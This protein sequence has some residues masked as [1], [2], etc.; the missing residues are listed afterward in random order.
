MEA[1]SG[2]KKVYL[3]TWGKGTGQK[4]TED[5]AK[6]SIGLDGGDM[7]AGPHPSSTVVWHPRMG[8]ALC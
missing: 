5:P 2:L 6:R 1:D 7:F 3:G 8:G 4:N